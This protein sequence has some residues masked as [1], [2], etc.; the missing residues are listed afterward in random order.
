MKVKQYRQ[1]ILIFSGILIVSLLRS[2]ATFNYST[3]SMDEQFVVPIALGFLD[4]DLNPKWFG[5]N[6]LPMYILSVL[7]F[8][9]YWVF[10]I[11]GIVASKIEFASLLYSNDVV[12][13]GSARLLFSFAHTL[14]LFT[15]AFIIYRNYK[16]IAGALLFLIIAILIPDSVMAAN[17]VRVDTFVFLFLSLTIYFSCFAKKGKT[18]YFGSLLACTAAFASKLPAIVLF[19]ILFVKFSYDIIQGVYPRYYLVYFFALPP[20]FL[21]FFMPYLFIDY[22]TYTAFLEQTFMKVG[23]GQKEHVGRLY[24]DDAANKV[25]AVYKLIASNAGAASLF[26]TILAGIYGLIRDRDLMF[27][28]LFVLGYSTAFMTSSWTD[29]WWLRPVYP[30]FIFFTIILVLRLMSHPAVSAWLQSLSQQRQSKMNLGVI[31]GTIP[32]LVLTAYYGV[33]FSDSFSKS[34]NLLTETREDTRLTASQ[35]IQKNIP[36]NSIIILDTF[37]AH[38]LPKAFSQDKM[39][40]FSSFDY[41]LAGRNELLRNGFIFYFNNNKN[42]KPLK[43]WPLYSRSLN[44]E[45][46]K[47]SIPRG[48]YIIISSYTY[49]RYYSDSTKKLF[50]ILTQKALRYYDFIKK[51]KHIKDFTGRGPDIGIYQV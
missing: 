24:L 27:S 10:S 46:G 35:W 23:G 14:G 20:V 33:S 34:Y 5:Y 26:G 8:I 50:P 30:F 9:I 12:F 11:F 18:S 19:P 51:Q 31:A 16:S 49:D 2:G 32:L 6:T 36:D 1:Y 29:S 13:Y 40:T 28:V 43:V 3:W 15:L 42:Q 4:Y 22:V 39:T 37:L 48:A 44:F 21:F 38:Y 45:S 47:I 17:K 41:V 7:Y 25:T